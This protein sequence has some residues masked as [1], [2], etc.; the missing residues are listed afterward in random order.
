MAVDLAQWRVFLAVAE[1]GSLMKAAEHLHTDQPALSRA[2]RRLERQ[3]GAPL[4]VRSSR[5][6]ALTDLG[7][8][9]HDPVRRLAEQADAVEL[10]AQAEA[11]R[12]SGVLKIGTVDAYPINSAI[13]EAA[14]SLTVGQQAMTAE[15]VGLPWLAHAAAVLN[16][17]IDIG[18]TLVI[19]GRLSDSK[20]LRSQLLWEETR[21]FALISAHHPLAQAEEIHPHDLAELPLH[22][23][24]KNDNPDVYN[25]VLELLADAGV[26]APRRAAPLGT[27]ANVIAHVAAGDGW[28]VSARSLARNVVP[29]TVAKPLAVTP[30][31]AVHF[32]M[33][34]H[35]D[36]DPTTVRVVADRVQAVFASYRN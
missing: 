17:T 36:Q 16:R 28:L 18:F 6:L 5:G 13:A 15:I 35:A 14:Q 12:A 20:A 21:A 9:L 24:D 26:P 2:L 11:R 30:R 8:R 3:I 33:I 32:A 29:G 27:F 23:P 22:L 4:F 10:Q 25:F 31:R 1:R 19:G 34:W 7:A